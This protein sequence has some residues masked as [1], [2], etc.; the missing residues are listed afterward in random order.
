MTTIGFDVSKK[1]LVGAR[2]NQSGA[3]KESYTIANTTEAI[4]VFLDGLLIDQRRLRIASEATAEYH[5]LLAQ[6]CLARGIP[7]ALINPIMTK[8]F[9]RATVRKKKTD[10]SDALIIAKLALQGEGTLVTRESFLAFK[11]IVR[12]AAKLGRMTQMLNLM[13]RRI[14][15][16]FPQETILRAALS[17]PSETL[18][19][20]IKDLRHEI[21]LALD[22]KSAALL[23]SIPGIGP[24]IT[25]TLIA[26]IGDVRR[27]PSGKALVAYAG[28]DP[29]VRQ[30]G[31]SLNKNTHLTKRGSPYLR[32]AVYIAASIAQRH[33]E[34]LK[35]YFQ[36]KR[37][38]GKGYKEA[39]IATAR[40]LL[41]RVYAVWK[42]GTPY[43][44]I[45]YP[46]P[47]A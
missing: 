40:K 26:E 11:T 22:Q 28:L 1:E 41:Y 27:F 19:R 17:E 20:S 3:L 4:A 44:T 34:E 38:E 29:R 36:K 9:T 39:T 14:A 43:E 31:V 42:R 16:V 46:Q 2:V 5:R 24:T 13:E 12:T 25:A 18:I 37:N 15:A 47:V 8:Q 32:R 33:H 21:A 6:E 7:F 23:A 45:R 35:I 30:S 10:A